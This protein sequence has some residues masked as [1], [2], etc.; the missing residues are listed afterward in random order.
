MLLQGFGFV[1]SGIAEFQFRDLQGRAFDLKLLNIA[2]A[3]GIGENGVRERGLQAA[4]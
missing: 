2:F 4:G 1:Q 3:D